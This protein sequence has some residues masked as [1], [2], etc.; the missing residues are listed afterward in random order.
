L[1][2]IQKATE[3]AKTVTSSSSYLYIK[4]IYFP[5]FEHIHKH[6]SAL[7]VYQPSNSLQVDPRLAKKK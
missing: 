4:V 3:D 1:F 6:L 2:I 5:L 7:Y